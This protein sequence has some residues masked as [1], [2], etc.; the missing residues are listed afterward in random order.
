MAGTKGQKKKKGILFIP[1]DSPV[2]SLDPRTK[3]LMLVVFSILS[4]LTTNP[5]VMCLILA[6]VVALAYVSGLFEKWLY[7]L[8]LILPLILFVFV[9]DLFFSHQSA[10]A[11][12]FSAQIG[13][14]HAYATEGSLYFSISMV[15]RLLIIAG[16][17]FLFI[18]T[19]QYSDF[20]K[21]L[22]G[23]KV[24]HII[25][26]SLGYALSSTTTL[27]RDANNV[28]E[29]QKSRG[30]EFD[31]GSSITKIDKLLSLFIPMTVIMLN[32][33]GQVSDA[34]QCRGYG[35]AQKPTIY[36]A[37]VIGADDGVA[38]II[39]VLF[40]ILVILLTHFVFI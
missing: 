13:F 22:Q 12:F 7:S 21:G 27:S 23:M 9:I 16:F 25:S 40:V 10:G 29:A 36:Q 33:S 38:V 30:L 37:P 34:M 14:I 15:T 32:R 17:S 20:V 35:T 18:M 3:L 39:L 28:I 24:P 4:F 8:R 31:Q 6:C 11:E 2:H 5:F 1:G 26:F 19:T